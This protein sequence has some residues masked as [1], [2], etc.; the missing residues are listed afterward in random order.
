MLSAS[1]GLSPPC[2]V[3]ISSCQRDNKHRSGLPITALLQ[4][5]ILDLHSGR[6]SQSWTICRLLSPEPSLQVWCLLQAEDVVVD[7][8]VELPRL[9]LSVQRTPELILDW[10]VRPAGHHQSLPPPAVEDQ[11]LELLPHH[12]TVGD[13]VAGTEL[14]VKRV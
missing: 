6:S 5:Q 11:V 14:L 2:D 10:L 3:T 7:D 4:S 9:G 12:A 13:V 8:A 1:G